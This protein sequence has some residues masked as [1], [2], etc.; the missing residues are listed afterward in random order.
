[1]PLTS[2]GAKAGGVKS[3]SD[4]A[5]NLKQVSDFGKSSRRFFRELLSAHFAALKWVYN[6]VTD[7]WENRGGEKLETRCSRERGAC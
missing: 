6:M 3:T 7:T 4:S 2:S 5:R 1:M